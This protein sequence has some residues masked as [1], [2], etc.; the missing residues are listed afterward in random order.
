MRSVNPHQEGG[1]YLDRSM[2]G[3][4]GGLRKARH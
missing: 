3:L 1:L 2:F 4:A